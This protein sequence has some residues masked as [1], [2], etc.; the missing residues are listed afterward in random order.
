MGNLELKMYGFVN[1]QLCGTIHAGIQ[2]GHAVVEYGVK[3]GNTPEYSQWAN[4]DKTFIILNGGTTNLNPNNPGTLNN[5]LSLMLNMDITL[6]P[7]YEPDL[8]DQLTSFVF[9]V[10]ERVYNRTKY[11]DFDV[12]LK[13][14][15]GDNF[16]FTFDY[17]KSKY[18]TDSLV[19]CF[20]THY[21]Q[22]S[23]LLGGDR[24]VFLRNYLKDFKL[25]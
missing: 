20:G 13:G 1:Y 22:W 7:F 9:L 23:Q 16:S 5:N 6:A 10:D 25:A 15:I 11:P 3:Y 24:N 17:N 18:G 21:K 2:F 4:V 8:G 12:W 19:E 14:V